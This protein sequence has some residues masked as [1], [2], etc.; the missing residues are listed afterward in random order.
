MEA[1]CTRLAL[2]DRARIE[3]GLDKGLSARR[4]AEDIGRS[5]ATVSREVRRNRTH[6][7]TDSR[8][9]FAC[10]RR[11]VCVRTNACRS[12][13]DAT[14]VRCAERRLRDCRRT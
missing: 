3:M 9:L 10:R 5:A 12:C 8:D 7:R 1:R 4:I 11:D 2:A 14:A 13:A 6:A